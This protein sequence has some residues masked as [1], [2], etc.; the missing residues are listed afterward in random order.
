MRFKFFFVDQHA[1]N[2][3]FA[4]SLKQLGDRINLVL[5]N[6]R[7]ERGGVEPIAPDGG[8]FRVKNSV[9][10]YEQSFTCD[11]FTIE[12]LVGIVIGE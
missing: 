7:G 3:V 12:G 2:I 4:E 9:L 10:A 5:S 6:E 11:R 1:R 8:K